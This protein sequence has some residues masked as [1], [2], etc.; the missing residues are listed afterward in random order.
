MD[1]YKIGARESLINFNDK[2]AR[3]QALAGINVTGKLDDETKK[4]FI[5]PRCGVYEEEDSP[6]RLSDANQ[7]RR[8]RFNLQ[9]SYWQKKVSVE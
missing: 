5:I 7:G 4:L 3:V 2:I 8:K 1:H 9:G 6:Q